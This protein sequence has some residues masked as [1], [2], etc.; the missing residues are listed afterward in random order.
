MKKIF[1]LFLAFCLLLCGIRI[2][3]SAAASG[4]TTYYQS[5]NRYFARQGLEYNIT[6]KG[7]MASNHGAAREFPEVFPRSQEKV[8][9]GILVTNQNNL[10]SDFY[11][12]GNAAQGVDCP[13]FTIYVDGRELFDGSVMAAL[14]NNLYNN[15]PTGGSG[16]AYPTPYLGGSSQKF[17]RYSTG[18]IVNDPS[19]GW[20]IQD[21]EPIVLDLASLD[22]GR[23]TL[24]FTVN[25][26]Y[27]SQELVQDDNTFS[28][29]F[30]IKADSP[31]AP[32]A[33][34][35]SSET[36]SSIM[37]SAIPGQEYSIDGG[38]T[39]QVSGLFEGL[40]PET[41]YEVITRTAETDTAM[42]SGN[43]APLAVTTKPQAPDA[44]AAPVLDSVTSSSV[45]VS[46]VPGLEY[47]LNG[48]VWQ[49]GGIFTGLS[50]NTRYEIR[51]RVKAVGD[52]PCSEAGPALAVTTDKQAVPAP[53]APILASRTDTSV[54]VQIAAGQEY[55]IDGGVTWQVSDT[56]LSLAPNREYSILARTAETET[57]Y[58]SPSSPALMVKTKKPAPSA[59]AAPRLWSRTDTII[60]IY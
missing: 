29:D 47:S 12:S 10:A 2:P 38:T 23:H 15:H 31:L 60:T 14:Y 30:F 50:P 56:F 9:L 13:N 5:G 17:L 55:S 26:E 18:R 34:A 54:T 7:F 37:V 40:E 57:A 11:P 25:A 44:P 35:L 42:A 32:G 49:D 53:S 6:A 8:D 59:P 20:E 3:S 19:Y 46:T 43:S 52:M 24:S 39:W 27:V 4:L 33:P 36:S 1:S 21:T 48:A 51:A 16:A 58:A 22:Y 45:T 41:S 28:Q